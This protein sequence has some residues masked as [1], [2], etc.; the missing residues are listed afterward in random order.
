MQ[1]QSGKLFENRTLYYLYPCLKDYGSNFTSKLNS[2]FK[3][4]IGIGDNYHNNKI[5]SLYLLISHNYGN[6]NISSTTYRKSFKDF[7]NYIREH[8]AYIADYPVNFNESHMIVIRFPERYYI[9]YDN[10]LLGKYS[11][12]YDK[13]EI[14]FIYPIQGI[15]EKTLKRNLLSRAVI[16][17]NRTGLEHYKKV[18]KE[19]FNVILQD[20]D[21][22]D[23][24]EF[25]I[26]YNK[27]EEIFNF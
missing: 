19:E 15:S 5:K 16:N 7:L 24:R 14:D 18:I 21:C 9:A 11:K 10:F 12:M 13:S 17:K 25:D 3:L 20:S 27:K 23:N 2:V 26:P 8:S 6:S 4:A 1:I 22:M